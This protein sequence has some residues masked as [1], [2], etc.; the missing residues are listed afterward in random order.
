LKFFI[1]LFPASKLSTIDYL[2]GGFFL[3]VVYFS[4]FHH[5]I[6]FTAWN[7]L[8][9]LFGNPL[10]FYENCRKFQGAE[11][12]VIANYPPPIYII[13]ALWLYPLKLLGLIKSPAYFSSDLVYWLKALTSLI[14]IGT[15]FIFYNVTQVYCSEK[16]WGKYATW[17]WLTTPL[18]LFSQFIFSQYDIFY[19]FF[20]LWGFLFFLKRKVLLASLLF[21]LAITFKYFPFFV[22][23]PLLVFFEKKIVRLMVSG[24]VFAIPMLAIQLLYGHSPAYV[25]GVMGFSVIGR[26][27]ASYLAIGT[28]KI[29]TLFLLFALL[30][31][32]TYLLDN[33]K[34]NAN[35]VAAY[36]YLVSSVFPFL[37]I[38][39]HPQWLIFST[40]AI[41]L[42]T[43]LMNERKKIHRLLFY[44]LVGM[45]FF[46]AYI[47]LNFQNNADL[48]MLQ[49][50]IIPVD[51]SNAFNISDL[52]NIFKSF[53]ADLYLS[54]F[55]AYLV[56]QFIVKYPTQFE[57]GINSY[58]F[59]GD[60]R[61]R[62]Y[63]GLFIFLVPALL[64]LTLSY[65]N[66]DRYVVNAENI[67]NNKDFGELTAGRV[68]EQTFIAKKSILNRVD[69]FLVT[70]DRVNHQAFKMEILNN[71][72]KSIVAVKRSAFHVLA[73]RWN[74]FNLG[75]VKLKKG[76]LYRLRLFSEKSRTD[77][78][79]SWVAYKKNNYKEGFAIVDGITQDSS[80]AFRLKFGEDTYS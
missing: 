59:F 80:F 75:E 32:M 12:L 73:N 39:W 9:F 30:I 63:I 56:L 21:G 66:A 67:E 24:F 44:D 76:H 28:A 36:I 1:K 52:F 79:I 48:A 74:S 15:G 2:L 14:Y 5:D 42:T 45:F 54:A 26:V 38:I 33:T 35:K 23:I 57:M 17:L 70:F 18:A 37:F 58:Y 34:E 50:K 27:F 40:P 16:T 43:L 25:E 60:V 31:G 13:F 41:L 49:S 62:F 6:Y 11:N 78:A 51:M 64:A 61:L 77:D 68:F 29:Y 65:K 46:V 53:S 10:D 20:T 3:L 4:F 7:A 19:V 55:W 8:N 71:E 22:F 69:L 47:S 72:N